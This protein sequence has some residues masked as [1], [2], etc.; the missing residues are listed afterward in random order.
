MIFIKKLLKR[1]PRIAITGLNPHCESFD[2]ENKEKK[3][4]YQLLNI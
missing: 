2:N 3:K 1:K 4:L